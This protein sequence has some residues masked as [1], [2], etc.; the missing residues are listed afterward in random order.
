MKVQDW[1]VTIQQMIEESN[2]ECGN[3]KVVKEWRAK[4]AKEPHLLPS[5]QIDEIM[6]EVWKRLT[7]VSLQPSNGS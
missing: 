2:H 7:S 3:W 1:E 5:F 4:L 6:R